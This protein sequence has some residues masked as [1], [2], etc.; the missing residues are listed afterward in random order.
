[1]TKFARLV[2]WWGCGLDERGWDSTPS[3]SKNFSLQNI[4]TCSGARPAL[5]FY[6]GCC[7]L[8][9]WR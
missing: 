7:V 6:V 2:R 4:Q 1:M 5:F 3:R 8:F 9:S